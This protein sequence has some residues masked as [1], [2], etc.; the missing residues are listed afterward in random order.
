[1]D[2]T[3]NEQRFME[4]MKEQNAYKEALTV[5]QWDS[6]TQMPPG[7][8][9]SRADVTGI[10]SAKLQE[11][12]TSDRM[13]DMIEEMKAVS[14]NE[15]IL[16]AAEECNRIYEKS[17]KI[18]NDRY[19]QYVT[20]C[21]KSEAVWG[22]AR[23]TDDFKLFEPY[24]QQI[25][26]FNRE[27]A[28][29]WGYEGH[30]YN[31]LLDNHE[32]GVKVDM[33][34]EVFP[35][36]QQSL[37][38]LIE[39]VKASPLKAD[40]SLLTV[41]FP[42]TRQKAFCEAL[43]ERIGYRFSDGRLDTSAH[44]YSF[45]INQQDVRLS[46]KYDENDFRTSVFSAIHEGG[47]ALYEQNIAR[48]LQGTP[49]S[50]ASSMGMHESQ[51][52]YWEVFV[53]AD[54]GF[55]E[56]NYDWFREFSPS[57]FRSV[58]FDDFYL[59]LHDV[60]ASLIRI[61]ADPLTYPMHIMMRYELEKGL[62]TGDLNAA[63][64]PGAWNE[65]MEKHLGII[66]QTDRDGVLQDIHWSSGDFGY[67]PSYALGYL[68]AAQLHHSMQNEIP[69]S[70]CVQENDFLPVRQW[71]TD[72]IHQY[73]KTKRPLELLR[74]ATSEELNPRYLIDFYTKKYGAIYQF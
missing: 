13:K 62:M 17:R 9:D 31:A 35:A 5:L 20:L 40:T 18:P 52:L 46:T 26:S 10:L 57:H 61:D 30:P 6:H 47:H 36:L 56:T 42:A 69:F 7:G 29:R 63:E 59:A 11:S 48:R 21:S 49:L 33:L 1:M 22:E 16:Q 44:P 64:L 74:E 55:W 3:V 70:S 38:G 23:K 28:D 54:R 2:L 25:V 32:P 4:L 15:F 37:T 27:F 72:H 24:L 58:A 12:E 14:E 43:L 60:Q 67:F 71:F 41:P 53:A 68:Y 65:Q 66:P 73:G 34:D 39:Q 50:A 45:A 51:S 19:R 8:V